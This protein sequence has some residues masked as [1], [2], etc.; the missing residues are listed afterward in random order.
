MSEKETRQAH[1]RLYI[2]HNGK[3]YKMPVGARAGSVIPTRGKASKFYET[4]QRVGISISQAK[5]DDGTRVT[6]E[7]CTIAMDGFEPLTRA[8]K[9]LTTIVSLNGA[10]FAIVMLAFILIMRG[11]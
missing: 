10:V 5:E 3:L 11:W 2:E 1:G 6:I 4:P 7:G 9:E 8:V